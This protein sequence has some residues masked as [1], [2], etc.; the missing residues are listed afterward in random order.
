MR[1]LECGWETADSTGRCARC[2]AP[3]AGQPFAGA[4]SAGGARGKDAR[5]GLEDP[6]RRNVLTAEGYETTSPS[7][8]QLPIRRGAAFAGA[9]LALLAGVVGLISQI[10]FYSPDNPGVNYFGFVAFLVPIGV[11]VAALRRIDRLV[12]IGLLQGMWWPAVAFVAADVVG[13]SVDHMYGNTGSVLAADWVLVASDVLGAAA[14][15][16]LVVSWS[17]AVGWHRASR[18]RPLPV[19]LLC[20]VGASQIVILIFTFTRQDTNA[21]FE[22]QGIAGLL[23][24]LG[25][26]WYAVNLRASALGGALVLG[27]ST[28]TVLW[29]MYAMSP[30]T[31]IGVLGCVLVAAVMVLALIY[32]R[33]QTPPYLSRWPSDP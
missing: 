9:G 21:G 20:G 1:C 8:S 7:V 3:V 19:M 13:S 2:G 11:A 28:V 32:M 5:P 27:W 26:T 18:L 10:L 4:G 24:G 15:I 22:T 12:I 30:W 31:A 17:S 14:A 6:L 23:V 16:L 29:L 33:D 25:V